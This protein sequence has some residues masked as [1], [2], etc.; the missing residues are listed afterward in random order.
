MA[1][2]FQNDLNPPEASAAASQDRFA[3]AARDISALGWTLLLVGLA[4]LAGA[5]VLPVQAS[6]LVP[7]LAMMA[8]VGLGL[9]RRRAWSRPAAMLL[10][11]ALILGQL[12]RRWLESELLKPMVDALSGVHDATRDAWTLSPPPAAP[13]SLSTAVGGA[14]L[15]VVMGWFFVRLSSHEVRAEFLPQAQARPGS[16]ASPST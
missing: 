14:L 13:L 4:A 8:L 1:R 11:C 9:L 3:V 6:L 2:M 16:P 10:F 7:T 15:C 5:L 12:S